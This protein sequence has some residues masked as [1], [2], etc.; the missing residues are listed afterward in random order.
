MVI[1][2]RIFVNFGLTLLFLCGYRKRL[3]L[4]NANWRRQV[5]VLSDP[6]IGKRRNCA[7]CLSFNRWIIFILFSRV[8]ILH[9]AKC[10]LIIHSGLHTRILVVISDFY[11]AECCQPWW[12][13]SFSFYQFTFFSDMMNLWVNGL[14][15]FIWFFFPTS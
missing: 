8:C 13:G 11:S 7:C 2:F 9:W 6:C 5:D 14:F 1:F 3:F 15:W 4:S 12:Y 10:C